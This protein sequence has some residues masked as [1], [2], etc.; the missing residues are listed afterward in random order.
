MGFACPVADVAL[1]KTRLEPDNPLD[2]G[3]MVPDSFVAFRE[4]AARKAFL[5]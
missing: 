1:S 4:L 3:R 5:T 2:S